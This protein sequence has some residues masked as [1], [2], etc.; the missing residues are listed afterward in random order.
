[1]SS[2]RHELIHDPDEHVPEEEE[3][4]PEEQLTRQERRWYIMGALKSTLLI[5]SAYV[6]GFAVIILLMLWFWT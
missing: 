1:M 6:I 4:R 5:G 3:V 2:L